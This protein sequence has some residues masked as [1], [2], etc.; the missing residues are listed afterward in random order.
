MTR[1]FLNASWINL[2]MANFH[3]DK[4]ILEPYTPAF[5][6]VD[7]W[8]GHYYVSLVGFLFKDT[9]V[10]GIRV[11]FHTDFEEVNLRFYVRY[12]E[13]GEWKRGVV[14]IKELVPRFMI[15]FIANTLY[16][17]HY[18]T[19]KM[20][21]T[22]STTAEDLSV[23][24]RWMTGRELNYLRASADLVKKPI[25]AGSEEEF[26]TEHYWGYTRVTD[27]KTTAYEVQHPKWNI[28][29]IRSFTFQCNV[30][31][32]YGDRF[33]EPLAA[34]PTSVFLADGSA[35]RVMNKQTIQ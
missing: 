32:L 5:T 8:N 9:A 30:K 16:H 2:L 10:S 13:N 23:E 29:P 7:D 24:Y 6:E 35:I 26:I 3:V 11:P 28:H 25:D 14:F 20:S 17:E 22:F 15:T 34:P 27:Q 4:K 21:H 18:E 33:V 31:E 12:K 1:S 19:R